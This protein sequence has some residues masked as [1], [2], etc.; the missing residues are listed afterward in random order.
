MDL[1]S[2]SCF[3]VNLYPVRIYAFCERVFIAVDFDIRPIG[4]FNG[5]HKRALQETTVL[6]EGTCAADK[7]GLYDI[8]FPF[9]IIVFA[10]CVLDIFLITC[11]I[12]RKHPLRAAKVG[13]THA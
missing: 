1:Y 12:K 6:V 4:I 10:A 3:E 5:N 13:H 7:L 9:D 2:E 11:R 8:T